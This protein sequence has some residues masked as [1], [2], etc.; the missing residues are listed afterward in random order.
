[1]STTQKRK[2]KPKAPRKTKAKQVR[3]RVARAKKPVQKPV[4]PTPSKKVVAP[5]RVFLLA[6]RLKGSFGV[7]IDVERT[8]AS[9]RLNRRFNAVLLENSAN[10]IAS[11]RK[12]KDYVTWGEAKPVDIAM[13]L[14]ERGELLAGLP[15]TDKFAHEKFGVQSV[16][17]IASA[18]ADGSISLKTL[19]KK[20]LRPVFRLRPPTGGFD[21]STKRPHGTRGE[22]GHRG[23]EVTALVARMS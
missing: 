17:G 9:L 10:V 20:G 5:E 14:R 6:I 22:L 4:E 13:L 11:L 15:L 19:L 18:L 23:P 12:V 21:A 3:R 8:L 1:M 2:V 7:P 16:D